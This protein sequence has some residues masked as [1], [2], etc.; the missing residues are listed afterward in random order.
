VNSLPSAFSLL[1]QTGTWKGFREQ[2]FSRSSKSSFCRLAI[3]GE[4]RWL[5][6]AIILLP[7]AASWTAPP[8]ESRPPEKRMTSSGLR[9]VPPPGPKS[10]YCSTDGG[11][12]RFLKVKSYSSSERKPSVSRRA[13]TT[14]AD[15]Q[16]S[17]SRTGMWN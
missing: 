15:D 11:L 14:G 13:V 3:F 16:R 9:P 2:C 5:T 7:A 17:G 10:R 1:I 12:F 6:K 8:R 4:D